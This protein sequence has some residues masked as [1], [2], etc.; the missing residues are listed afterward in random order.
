MACLH[1][2]QNERLVGK[3]LRE[4]AKHDTREREQ[5]GRLTLPRCLFSSVLRDRCWAL[6]G[7]ISYWSCVDNYSY[8]NMKLWVEKKR[9]LA[10]RNKTSCKYILFSLLFIFVSLLNQQQEMC[11]HCEMTI[12]TD[13]DHTIKRCIA[14]V[15]SS[16][17]LGLF[18]CGLI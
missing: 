1:H 11:P 3:A 5:K 13:P 15:L 8:S 18:H 12:S 9:K 2:K 7:R 6:M 17:G 10:L 16:Q 4:T 14:S